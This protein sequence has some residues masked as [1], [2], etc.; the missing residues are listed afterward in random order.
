MTVIRIIKFIPLTLAGLLFANPGMA[1][2]WQLSA[3]TGAAINYRDD[4]TLDMNSGGDITSD[5]TEWHTDPFNGQMYYG[6]RLSREMGPEYALELEY[7]HHK[8][9]AEKDDLDPRIQNFT[10]NR[11]D[12]YYLNYAAYVSPTALV[13]VGAGI[14]SVSSDV[15]ID[16]QRSKN[17]NSMAGGSLQLGLEK[18]LLQGNNFSFS[19][20]S[21]MSYSYTRFDIGDGKATV[22]NTALHFLAH[23]NYSL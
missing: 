14:V 20:E 11:Y 12:I 22:P 10:I 5:D 19:L 2:T 9:N 16:S 7:L 1:Q 3:S 17:S 21:K 15:T 8:L 23:L 4:I 6:L 18:I 13:R